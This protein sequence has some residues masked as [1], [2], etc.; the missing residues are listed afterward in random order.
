MMTNK[1][2]IVLALCILEQVVGTS[3]MNSP[4]TLIHMGVFIRKEKEIKIGRQ[5]IK[6]AEEGAPKKTQFVKIFQK[7]PK[8]AFFGLFFQNFACGAKIS[9]KTGTF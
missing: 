1:V 5:R 4:L 2:S 8:N 6:G 3:K 9:A 7:V